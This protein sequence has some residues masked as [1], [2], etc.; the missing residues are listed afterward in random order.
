MD[1]K[2]TK[3]SFLSHEMDSKYE[4]F[5]PREPFKDEIHSNY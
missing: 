3:R 5:T 4:Y 1:V 2:R